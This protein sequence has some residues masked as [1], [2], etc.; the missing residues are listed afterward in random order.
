MPSSSQTLIDIKPFDFGSIKPY[1]F[2]AFVAKRRSGKSTWATEFNRRMASSQWGTVVVLAG[3]EN[4]KEYWKS[5]S[6]GNVHPLYVHDPCTEILEKVRDQQ[7]R[8]I[9]RAKVEKKPLDDRLHHVTI[10]MDDV[11]CNTHI[12]KSKILSYLASNGRQLHVTLMLML[13]YFNQMPA[14]L[15]VQLDY[16]VVLATSHRRNINKLYDE[17]AS[18]V[19]PRVFRSVLNAVT[20]DYGAMVIDNTKTDVHTISDNCFYSKVLKFP[21]DC[22]PLGCRAV[23]DYAKEHYMDREKIVGALKQHARGGGGGGGEVEEEEG[24][25]D[26]DSRLV[27]SEE[28]LRLLDNKRVYSDSKGCII[29]RRVPEGKEKRD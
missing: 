13:Q 19:E 4:T 17:F 1:S 8:R 20:G 3:S 10:I 21:V 26:V 5:E 23:R 14:E 7:N 18:S 2:L 15:R 9:T 27:M 12:M 11:G 28:E 6:G 22:P 29:V 24:L 25:S 16:V